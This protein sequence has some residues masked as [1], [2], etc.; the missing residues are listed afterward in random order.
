M[1]SGKRGDHA[2]RPHCPGGPVCSRV[3]PTTKTKKEQLPMADDLLSAAATSDGYD[4]TSIE[5]L[6]G[7]R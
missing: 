4:A 2:P 3:S 6:E 1:D 5:V 7:L